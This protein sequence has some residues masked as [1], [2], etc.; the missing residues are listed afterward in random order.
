MPFAYTVKTKSALADEFVAA[1]ASVRVDMVSFDLAPN[2]RKAKLSQVF[3]V[4]NDG[5]V[6]S[7]VASADI[8]GK[9]VEIVLTETSIV[10][11]VVVEGDSV[12]WIGYIA[13]VGTRAYGQLKSHAVPGAAAADYDTGINEWTA[14]GLEFY[15]DRHEFSGC[16]TDAGTVGHVIGF[17]VGT[18][19][20]SRQRYANRSTG[21]SGGSYT[22]S[23]SSPVE[24]TA[25]D[26]AEHIIRVANDEFGTSFAL[27]GQDSALANITRQW[28]LTGLTYSAA[29]TRVINPKDGFVWFVD[30]QSI[31]VRTITD[32]DILESGTATVLVP[33]N[34]TVLTL[35]LAESE[36]SDVPTIQ[37]VENSHFD[38]IVVRGAR[39]VTCFTINVPWS[40]LE[41]GWTAA[42]ETAYEALDDSGSDSLG[43]VY[44]RYVVPAGWNGLAN[45]KEC[46]PRVNHATGAPDYTTQQEF[47]RPDLRFMRTLPLPEPPYV[48]N[49]RT[50]EMRRPFGMVL[51]DAGKFVM[52][53]K[54]GDG[55]PGSIRMLDDDL[56]VIIGTPKQHIYGR[57]HTAQSGA[58]FDYEETSFTVAMETD[59]HVR[60][61][62]TAVDLEPGAVPRTKFIDIPDAEL[63]TIVD[64]TMTD[65]AAD[66]SAVFQSGNAIIRNDSDILS[67]TADI[68]Q[69]WYGRTRNRISVP[70]KTAIIL[71]HLGKVVKETTIGGATVPTGTI[72]NQIRYDVVGQSVN[73]NT[74]FFDLNVIGLGRDRSIAR[75]DSRIRNLERQMSNVPCRIAGGGDVDV[76]S[77]MT[78]SLDDAV[79]TKLYI[80]ELRADAAYKFN[81][82][83]IVGLDRLA[84]SAAE[85][86]TISATGENW[87]GYKISKSGSTITATPWTISGSAPP[88]QSDG[89]L[90]FT[91]GYVN[92]NGSALNNLRQTWTGGDIHI[93]ARI[94]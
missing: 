28:D 67:R 61:Q 70:Y 23:T 46:L 92:Y 33:K 2:I 41:K 79:A 29:L 90:Y 77:G 49:P 10:G 38:Q 63:W 14:Y 26:V 13:A 36:T 87:V 22:F 60:I 72:I 71:D 85:A 25:R 62:R 57:N 7:A 81:D 73:V 30:N 54:G 16:A 91:L 50:G 80:G 59:D 86:L 48:G 15:L 1:P 47:W 40:N 3:G 52:I 51:D 12:S 19:T 6:E 18:G 55:A 8:V 45:T 89:L 88:A 44:T 83:I 17:N 82:L 42:E 35:N 66:G 93:P 65:I 78:L 9:I 31:E 68:A 27:A 64:G 11:G 21:K 58:K 53:E 76:S 43:H 37:Q 20:R 94:G 74:D 34:S 84:K 39:M 75:L 69:S 32:V 56:G 24:W 4:V 5:S